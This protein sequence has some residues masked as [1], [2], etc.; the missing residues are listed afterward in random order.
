[1]VFLYCLCG[2]EQKL[3]WNPDYRR[4][5]PQPY[6]AKALYDLFLLNK[7]AKTELLEDGDK[8]SDKLPKVLRDSLISLSLSELNL[9]SVNSVQA[10]NFFMVRDFIELS[11][12]DLK[13]LQLFLLQGG[14]VLLSA[15][16][17]SKNILENFKFNNKETKFSDYD[18]A[19]YKAPTTTF[20]WNDK[21][22]SKKYVVRK[23][24]SNEQLFDFEKG[25]R[26]ILINENNEIQAI[27]KNI[28]LG[29]LTICCAPKL[30]TNITLLYQCPEIVQ[31]FYNNKPNKVNYWAN[32][33]YAQDSDFKSSDRSLLMFI[34][35]YKELKWAWYLFLF[36]GIL[37]VL[38]YMRRVQNPVS[39]LQPKRNKTLDFVKSVAMLYQK[40]S[41]NKSIIRKKIDMFNCFLF[42]KF[43]IKR[44]M[45]NEEKAQILFLKSNKD[46]TEQEI[47]SSL[48]Y[49]QEQYLAQKVS[50]KTFVETFLKIEKIKKNNL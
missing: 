10:S 31:K 13:A 20:L 3:D 5:N 43:D 32:E 25:Y 30:F 37:F 19:L 21:G 50:N 46:M 2:C 4:Q 42:D 28:G 40:S 12:N 6:G 17:F 48:V 44:Q 8:I 7:S 35:K 1:M 36:G 34:K 49:I 16:T 27:R 47:L 18:T 9:L 23:W 22:F 29:E 41:D 11:D 45:A 26:S 15:N 33:Y 39:K 24:S 38:N 14:H